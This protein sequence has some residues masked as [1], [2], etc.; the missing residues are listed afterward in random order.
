MLKTLL[1]K[2]LAIAIGATLLV[3]LYSVSVG[4]PVSILS[5]PAPDIKTLTKTIKSNPHHGY[6]HKQIAWLAFQK[7]DYTLAKKHAYK[8]LNNNLTDGLSMTILMAIFDT[9]K[10]PELADQAAQLSAHL[11][12]AHDTTM[13]L[14][15][16]HWIQ[17]KDIEKAMSAWNVILNQDPFEEGLFF[18]GWAAKTIFPILNRIA[19]IESSTELFQPYHANPP[20]WWDKFFQYMVKQPKNLTA[21]DRFYQQTLL[22]GKASESN[23]K[24]YLSNLVNEGQWTKAISVWEKGLA[25][26]Y[27]PHAQL[28]YDASFE[29]DLVNDYFS[30]FLTPKSQINVFRDRYSKTDGTYSLHITFKSWVDDYWGW[31]RQRMVL[32]PG[33]Y[34]LEFQTRARLKS[35]KGLKWR[36]DCLTV[37]KTKMRNIGESQS[38]T[39]DF[40]WVKK[41]FNFTVPNS[42]SCEAQEL[43]LI[44]AGNSASENRMRGDIWFDNFKITRT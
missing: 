10:K 18:D 29:T 22:N 11:W 36:L 12:P 17:S 2:T 32:K 26:D 4:I 40:D 6:A 30:W 7:A 41:Q 25:E 13:R 34:K 1:I 39:G 37:D 9:E 21:V 3:R 16:Y 35:H 23:N 44:P 28:M 14:I 42:A 33:K 31:I 20:P 43:Y 38:I 24:L 19:Q 5:R 15:S 8:A 27:K